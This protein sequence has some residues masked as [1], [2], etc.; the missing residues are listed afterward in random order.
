MA[1]GKAVDGSLVVR[2]NHQ[3]CVV[4]HAGPPLLVRQKSAGDVR[5]ELLR[6]GLIFNNPPPV[7]SPT[8]TSSPTAT[9]TPAE[10]TTSPPAGD[11]AV[12]TAA[13]GHASPN[14]EHDDG[15]DLDDVPDDLLDIYVPE[16][17]IEVSDR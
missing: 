5:E 7:L 6:A 2:T 13:L 3:S 8:N 17:D 4:L 11:K 12:S 15:V 10:H 1:L 9:S 14:S 16:E